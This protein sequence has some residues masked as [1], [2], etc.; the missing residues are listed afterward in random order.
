MD[1]IYQNEIEIQI[2]I[3]AAAPE[4]WKHLTTPDLMKMWMLDTGMKMEINTSWKPGS[5]II[6]KGVLHDLNFQ[7]TGTIL[8]YE[9]NK[10][11]VYTHLSSISGL[12]DIE[13]NFCSLKFVLTPVDDYIQLMLKIKNFPTYSIFKHMQFYWR[14]AM[15]KL[16]KQVEEL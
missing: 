5:P 3:Q 7:N 11:L 2:N 16:K 12:D 1:L 8:S 9:K 4:V 15:V 6:M 10:L 14:S 13:N